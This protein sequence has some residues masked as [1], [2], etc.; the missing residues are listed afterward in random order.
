MIYFDIK[1]IF[2][3]YVIFSLQVFD[4]IADSIE[5]FLKEETL[6][7]TVNIPLGKIMICNV[8]TLKYRMLWGITSSV[9]Q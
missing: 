6:D 8:S 5:V 2:E 4:H 9:I 1:S 7:K 3:N